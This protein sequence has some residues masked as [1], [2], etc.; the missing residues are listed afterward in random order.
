M[1][2]PRFAA[3]LLLLLLLP[4]LA[5]NSAWPAWPNQ[6]SHPLWVGWEG[7]PFWPQVIEDGEGGVLVAWV[8]SW[9]VYAQRFEASGVRSPGWPQ[10]GA[11]AFVTGWDT[12]YF[13]IVSDGEGGMF[14]AVFDRA[15][16]DAVNANHVLADGTSAPGWPP[17]ASVLG[18]LG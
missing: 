10:G 15:N 12:R 9:Q 18:A 13:N 4:L 11:P 14:V 1:A 17:A 2:R 7:G 6:E 3:P 16:G 5:P 8:S